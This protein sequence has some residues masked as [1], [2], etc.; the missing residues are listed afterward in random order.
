MMMR[1]VEVVIGMTVPVNVAVAVVTGT[2]T[3]ANFAPDLTGVEW[4]RDHTR[5]RSFPIVPAGVAVFLRD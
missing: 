1:V 5:A 4:A 2:M 3:P